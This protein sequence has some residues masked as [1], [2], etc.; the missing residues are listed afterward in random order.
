MPHVEDR[1]SR[2]PPRSEQARDVGLGVRVVALA[3]PRLVE[4]ILHIDDQQRR[5]RL[6]HGHTPV[7][8]RL[9]LVEEYIRRAVTMSS[10][11]L[12]MR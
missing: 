12:P 4:G 8:T 11:A 6:Q 2:L 10:T 1:A 5:S 3:P 7:L 9:M